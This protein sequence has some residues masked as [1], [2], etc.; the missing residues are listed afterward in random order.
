MSV[1]RSI[2]RPALAVDG[3]FADIAAVKKFLAFALV[4]VAVWLFWREPAADWKG[5]PAVREPVQS[6][7]GLPPAFRHEDYTVTPLARYSVTAVVLGR[8]RYRNDREADLSP[9]DFALGWG[10]MS[11][12]SVINELKISQSGR[13]YEYRWPGDPPLEP[14]QMATQSANT[15]CIPATKEVRTQLLSVKR[16]DL[17][18]L[19]GFLVEIAAPEGYRWRSSLT[20]TDS[21][22]RS[23]EVF[24]VTSVVR[25][26]L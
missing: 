11:M 23:C 13:W 3:D 1:C 2:R 26:T 10:S 7:S 15:H 14:A 20:R 9:V 16:H 19:E 6:E 24:W 4:V 12:A 25:K 22:A 5:I 21:G 18:T 8:E 17:V